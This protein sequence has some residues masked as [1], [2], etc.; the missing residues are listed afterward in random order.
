MVSWCGAVA[1]VLIFILCQHGEEILERHS[2]TF[3]IHIPINS[4]TFMDDASVLAHPSN[5]A[6]ATEK[7][8]HKTDKAGSMGRSMQRIRWEG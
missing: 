2:A 5:V 1:L 8:R 7:I 3:H 4:T 6:P